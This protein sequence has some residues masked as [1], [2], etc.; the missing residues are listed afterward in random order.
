MPRIFGW[1]TLLVVFAGLVG[2]AGAQD[3]RFDVW[4]TTT[5]PQ[6]VLVKAARTKS[7]ASLLQT[8]EQLLR[9]R[10]SRA[11]R[12]RAL[13]PVTRL[14]QNRRPASAKVFELYQLED[15]IADALIVVTFSDD[16]KLFTHMTLTKG[17]GGW[18]LLGLYYNVNWDKI[19]PRLSVPA[20]KFQQIDCGSG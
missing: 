16:I 12:D 9:G 1:I 13:R 7:S 14:V 17:R 11:E 5:E 8:F 20:T 3:T 6:C 10:A 2:P 18:V 4:Q 19:R 15:E